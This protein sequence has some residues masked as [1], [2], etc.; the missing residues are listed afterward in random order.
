MYTYKTLTDKFLNSIVEESEEIA[1]NYLLENKFEE[2]NDACMR[3]V[4]ATRDEILTAL[5]YKI[6]ARYLAKYSQD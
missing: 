1:L 4:Y 5:V 2:T 6:K 3:E